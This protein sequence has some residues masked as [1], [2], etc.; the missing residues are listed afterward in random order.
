MTAPGSWK[1]HV[2][3]K[4]V[5]EI[6]FIQL[7][8]CDPPPK[9]K[10][11][12]DPPCR[13]TVINVVP[14]GHGGIDYMYAEGEILV[15]DDYLERVLEILGHPSRP[16]L[17]RTEPSL[18][19]S[20]IAG[21]TRLTHLG[22]FATALGALEAIDA[23]LGV[24]IATPNHVLT[25]T[26]GTASHCPATEPEE[27]YDDIEPYPSVC[28][29][30]G[31]AGVQI[32]MADTGI[33]EGVMD[34]H[35]WLTGVRGNPD[36]HEAEV[37][38]GTIR[39]YAGHGTFAAGVARCM[40][41][42]AEIFVS[43]VAIT[44][45]S[46]LEADL[47]PGLEAALG[48]GVDIFHLC[49]SCM[50]RHDFPLI[51]FREWLGQLRQ[52]GGSVCVA[53]AGNSGMRR[54]SWPAAF[55]DVVAVG[56]LGGDWRGRA[57]FS[58]FGPWVDVYAPGRDLINAYATG[59]YT[60]HVAPYEGEVRKFYGMAKW[61]GT[62]FSTPIVTGLIA[63]RMSRTGE[64]GQEAAAALLEQARAQA[65]PGVGAVLLPCCR[66]ADPRRCCGAGHRHC[67][68]GGSRHC[69]GGGAP[70]SCCR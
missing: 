54:L 12:G 2:L 44:A 8:F 33:L 38:S 68:A 62:S 56:A 14:D 4:I 67:C 40:A 49:I 37:L 47:I 29:D 27:V 6:E 45:G 48:R 63:S 23:R 32:Y 11:K 31:G 1:D 69:C 46:V 52:Y 15:R 21:V 70:H 30:N 17:E 5:D 28:H 19:R 36:P 66:D 39:P 3:P 43:N 51:A 25:V 42:G 22:Q 53:A 60:C 50:S 18:V 61:S 16:E 58:N 64:N 34:S 24:G 59:D 9:Y 57:S 26:G 55:S 41:P 7:A 65:I 35:S 20:V 10:R 13:G